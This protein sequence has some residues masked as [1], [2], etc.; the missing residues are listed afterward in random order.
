MKRI[1]VRGHLP[2]QVGSAYTAHRAHTVF[3]GN[4]RRRQF[5]SAREAKAFQAE[6]NRLLNDVL[7]EANE[8]HALAYVQLRAAWPLFWDR[9]R[10]VMVET[11]RMAEELH[12]TSAD[13]LHK[14]VHNTTG[15]NGM[16]Y[17]FKFLS[18]ALRATQGQLHQLSGL[19]AYK[20]QGVQ[21]KAVLRLA[22][23]CQLL[24]D[25]LRECGA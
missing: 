15:P 9:Y 18:D 14:A 11:Q 8:L 12:A 22:R 10:P 23:N 2:G 19:Y 3:L 7:D 17:A 20:T 6:V 21:R 1:A 4:G 5:A 13:A 16:H 25:Q 24:L